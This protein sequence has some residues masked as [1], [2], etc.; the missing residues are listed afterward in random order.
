M[1]L[2]CMSFD[3]DYVLEKEKFSTIDE[4][5]V[6]SYDMGSRWYF[7]PFHFVVTNSLST[8]KDAPHP[9]KLMIGKRLSTIKALFKEASAKPEAQGMGPDEFAYYIS[10]SLS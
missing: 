9:F 2:V 4:A 1:R 10:L 5:W 6:H 8:I 3:G 7:C